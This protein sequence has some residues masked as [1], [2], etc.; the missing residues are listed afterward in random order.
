MYLQI[1]IIK[2]V[3][4]LYRAFTLFNFKNNY[5]LCFN[6]HFHACYNSKQM[7]LSYLNTKRSCLNTIFSANRLY[8]KKMCV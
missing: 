7:T 3:I 1:N 4:L 8:E 5:S 2:Y 6:Q